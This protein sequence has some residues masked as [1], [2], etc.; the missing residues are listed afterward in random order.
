MFLVEDVVNS[1]KFFTLYVYIGG[2]I[3]GLTLVI[4]SWIALFSA[5]KA[6]RDNQQQIDEALLPIKHKI[7]EMSMKVKGAVPAGMAGK[8]EE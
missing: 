4:L 5:P 8:K 6:Y 2:W 3:N 1:L 7:D